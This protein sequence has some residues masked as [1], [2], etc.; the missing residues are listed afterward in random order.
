MQ[1]SIAVL[2]LKLA[3]YFITRTIFV[4]TN[5]KQKHT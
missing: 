1:V 3:Q 2:G 5:I 4:K